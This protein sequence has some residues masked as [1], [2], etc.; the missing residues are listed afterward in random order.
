MSGPLEEQMEGMVI[1]DK[2]CLSVVLTSRLLS[3]DRSQQSY[4]VGKTPQEG[5]YDN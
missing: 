1:C 4:L 2:V 3:R 5:I